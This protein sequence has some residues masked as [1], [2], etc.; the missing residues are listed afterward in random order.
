MSHPKPMCVLQVWRPGLDPLEEDE[1]LQYDPTAYD[2]LHPFSTEWPALR[3]VFGG[4]FGCVGDS[5]SFSGLLFSYVLFSYVLF[6][7]VLF[8]Y[9][10]FSYPFS[11]AHTYSCSLCSLTP[12]ISNHTAST[13]CVTTWGTGEQHS[14]TPC[15]WWLAVKQPYLSQT[16]S[17]YLN[18]ATSTRGVMENVHW[19]DCII[20]GVLSWSVVYRWVV[21]CVPLGGAL[22]F[23]ATCV[24]L[25]TCMLFSHCSWFHP[26]FCFP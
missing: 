7:Y 25:N 23:C 2:C 4:C 10:L 13:Y 20:G 26:L 15:F 5:N 22:W 9:V 14:P 16:A 21:L 3:L 6:S 12:T 19:Y 18:Y 1:A 11:Y 17:P 24:L 8:S